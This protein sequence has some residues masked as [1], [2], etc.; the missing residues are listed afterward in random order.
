MSVGVRRDQ[1]LSKAL[2]S[3]PAVT[4][5]LTLQSPRGLLHLPTLPVAGGGDQKLL[6]D[7][8]MCV[9]TFGDFAPR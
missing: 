6:V 4:M 8:G 1:K 7:V 9:V 5:Q 3:D 2:R